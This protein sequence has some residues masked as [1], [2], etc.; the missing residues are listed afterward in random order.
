MDGWIEIVAKGLAYASLLWAV[1]ATAVQWWLLP[2]A[3]R[4]VSERSTAADPVG[5]SASATS[6]AVD[7]AILWG[8]AALVAA[9]AFRAVAHTVVAFGVADAWHWENLSLIALESQWGSAWQQ[10]ILV[11]LGWT[12]AAAASLSQRGWRIAALGAAVLM[13]AVTPGLGHAAGEPARL[14]VHAVHLLGAGCWIGT[15]AVVVLSRDAGLRS[16]R[17]QLL[18]AFAPAAVGSVAV[19]VVTGLFAAWTYLGPI[20]NLWA[21]TYGRLFGLKGLLV[22]DTLVLGALNWNRMHRQ[23]QPPSVSLAAGEVIV[24]VAVVAV[25]AWLTET[26]HP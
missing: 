17:P 3:L 2:R 5:R 9:L 12:A 24:S 20:E 25:T 18:E 15:L 4:G 21:T 11:A 8:A 10:Q 23:R 7:R 16:L 14:A 26:A 22:V 1:G 19:I 6:V 13:C